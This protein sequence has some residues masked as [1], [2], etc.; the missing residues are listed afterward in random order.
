[1]VGALDT[2]PGWILV[3]SGWGRVILLH[4]SLSKPGKRESRCEKRFVPTGTRV[5]GVEK[6]GKPF[7]KLAR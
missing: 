4:I 5:E 2:W 7:L 1:M 6:S 3:P